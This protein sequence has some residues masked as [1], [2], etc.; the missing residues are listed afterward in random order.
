MGTFL[1]VPVTDVESE[2]GSSSD[3]GL[4]FGVSAMQGWRSGEFIKVH[5]IAPP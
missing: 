5:S 1:S 3:L 2:E 4:A